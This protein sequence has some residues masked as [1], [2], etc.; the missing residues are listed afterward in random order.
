[1]KNQ[2]SV[3]KNWIS[4]NGMEFGVNNFDYQSDVVLMVTK[5]DE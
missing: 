3:Y 4:Q 2:N 1:M 5:S